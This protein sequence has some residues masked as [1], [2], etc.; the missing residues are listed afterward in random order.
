LLGEGAIVGEGRTS[1]HLAAQVGVDFH[2]A[3]RWL[4]DA[5]AALATSSADAALEAANRA[6]AVAD[7]GVLV[8][9]T[10]SWLEAWRRDLV[11]LGTRAREC[12]VLAALLP[13]GSG[14]AAAVERARELVAAEPYLESAHALLMR[15]LAAQGNVAHAL[16]VYEQLRTRL[17]E[18]LGLAPGPQLRE[19]HGR[20]LREDAPSAASALVLVSSPVG[21]PRCDGVFVGRADELHVLSDALE[22]ATRAGSRVVLV[23]GEAGIG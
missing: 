21:L 1:L 11:E 10:C 12:A 7:R 23:E 18:E 6:I 13:G 3:R 9:D 5:Q 15:A 19:L 17:T 4:S 16:T 2:D 14:L 22:A 8:G 20:L